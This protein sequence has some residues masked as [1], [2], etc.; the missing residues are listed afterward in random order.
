MQQA[1]RNVHKICKSQKMASKFYVN[2]MQQDDFHDD[3]IIPRLKC[4]QRFAISFS[5]D[6]QSIWG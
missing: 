5:R 1:I 4:A 2:C 6:C 3:K